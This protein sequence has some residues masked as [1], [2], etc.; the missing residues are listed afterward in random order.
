MD[1]YQLEF[2]TGFGESFKD[3][4]ACGKE[5]IAGHNECYSCGTVV[6][7]F[8]AK[9]NLLDTKETI[10]GIE[11][12]TPIIIKK[13]DRQW[14]QVVVNYHDRKGHDHFIELCRE[15]T[16]LPFAIYHYSKMLEIDKEDDI[17]Q[18]MRRQA[19]SLLT[20]PVETQ[21]QGGE[22][23]FSLTALDIFVRWAL[24]VGLVL[25]V[26]CIVAGLFIPDTRNLV[27]LGVASLTLF[28]ACAIYRRR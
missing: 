7:R 2:S 16:A 6:D 25:S 22:S 17:A 26:S 14:K 21:K 3:C 4:P 15:N 12:L 19:L 9:K 28:M 1:E 5:M 23:E 10:G 24:W 20:I 8:Q 27:G 13:L 18:I 11:H